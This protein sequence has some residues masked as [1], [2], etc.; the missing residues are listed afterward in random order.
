MSEAD[1]P[2]DV[3]HHPRRRSVLIGHEAAEQKLKDA[4]VSGRLH[5]AWLIGGPRGVGKATLA[6]RFARFILTRPGR[7]SLVVPGIDSAPDHPAASRL[8]AGA[9][10]DMLSL[11]R[12]F[13]PKAGRVR[14]VTTV[15][16]AREVPRF[17]SKTAG[18]GGWRVCVVDTAD[19]LNEASANTLLKVIEEPPSRSLIMLLSH[20]PGRLLATIRSRCV[21]VS[22]APLGDDQVTDVLHSIPELDVPSADLSLA[23]RLARGSPGRALE[24]LDSGAS[25]LFAV[26]RDLLVKLPELD[27]RRTLSF[28]DHLQGRK[29]DDGFAIFCE[30][31]NDWVAARARREAAHSVRTASRWAVAHGELSRSIDRTNALNLDRRQFVVHVFETLQDAARQAIH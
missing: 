2:R 10:C 28:A 3:P 20:A 25:R 13:D 11:E 27:M 31:L 18:E 17:F 21:K 1:D 26:A 4:Y 19:D 22:L 14:S 6:Y 24:L 23:A 30:L 16:L 9:H 7:E 29:G 5:S 8:A 12:A 15:D